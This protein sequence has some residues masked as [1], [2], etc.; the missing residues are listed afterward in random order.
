MGVA[1]AW[2]TFFVTTTVTKY[3]DSVNTFCSYQLPIHP[4]V[5]HVLSPHQMEL[6]AESDPLT[7]GSWAEMLR[8]TWNIAWHDGIENT[9]KSQEAQKTEN[10]WYVKSIKN[11]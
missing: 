2:L 7:S 8:F 3:R 1:S 10:L 9:I 11:I 6:P 4:A 5:H